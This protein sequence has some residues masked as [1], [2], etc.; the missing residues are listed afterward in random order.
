MVAPPPPTYSSDPSQE[1]ETIERGLPL[2]SAT[3]DCHTGPAARLVR[4]QAKKRPS[5]L[6]APTSERCTPLMVAVKSVGVAPKS[7]SPKACSATG[8]VQLERTDRSLARSL[9]IAGANSPGEEHA[10]GV[11]VVT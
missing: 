1:A 7:S 6:S 10:F 8:T 3:V 5:L 11:A 9:T 2:G 4:S